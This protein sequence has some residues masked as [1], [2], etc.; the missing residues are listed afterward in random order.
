MIAEY[1]VSDVVGGEGEARDFHQ[2]GF[3]RQCGHVRQARV[4][5]LALLQVVAGDDEVGGLHG[6]IPALD[7]QRS[8]RRPMT[9]L[10]QQ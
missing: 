3:L 9:V 6:S 2:Q 5:H 8:L 4:D 10:Q 7:M 1:G